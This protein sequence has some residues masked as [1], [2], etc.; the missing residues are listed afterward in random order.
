MEVL[1]REQPVE[2]IKSVTPEVDASFDPIRPEIID[3]LKYLGLTES[4]YDEEVMDKV[5]E[6]IDFTGSGDFQELDLRLGNPHN[7]TKLDKIY[8]YIRLMKQSVDLQ[9]RE[10]MLQQERNKY[11]NDPI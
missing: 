6:I 10:A 8:S 2:S 3:A 4:I 11:A 5:N 9:Q 7:M 1:K